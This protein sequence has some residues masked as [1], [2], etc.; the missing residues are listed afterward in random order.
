MAKVQIKY[1]RGGKVKSM[2]ERYA[3]ALVGA[4]LAEYVEQPKNTY[5]TRELK[6]DITQPEKKKPGRPKKQT[7]AVEDPDPLED[8]TY[9]TKVITA[10]E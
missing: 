6:A 5:K 4:K 1:K 10:E 2:D 8:N 7:V 9:S 3:K